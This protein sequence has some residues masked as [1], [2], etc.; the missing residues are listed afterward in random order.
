MTELFKSAYDSP[1]AYRRALDSPAAVAKFEADFKALRDCDA[2]VLL[3]RCGNDAHMEA[4]YTLGRNRPVFVLLPDA[5]PLPEPELMY[6]LPGV[7]IVANIDELIAHLRHS[8]AIRKIYV[9]SSWTKSTNHPVVITALSTHAEF[10]VFDYRAVT[11]GNSENRG[12]RARSSHL[13]THHS[14]GGN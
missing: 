6:R 4:A 10:E 14:T 9:A 13:Q 8:P 5:R 3:L 12:E 2:L 7:T 1:D 11:V